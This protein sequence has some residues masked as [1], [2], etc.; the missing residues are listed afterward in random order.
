MIRILDDS[1]KNL[2]ALKASGEIKEEDY[3]VLV[4]YLEEKIDSFG[5]LRLYL[6]ISDLDGMEVKAM[7]KDLK[8]DARHLN[9]FKKIAVVGDESWEKGLTEASRL[10]SSAETKFFD[11]QDRAAA[12]AWV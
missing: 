7:W 1:E 6:E 8:F 10:I 5:K 11:T 12:L 4:P 2:I 3:D 9:D